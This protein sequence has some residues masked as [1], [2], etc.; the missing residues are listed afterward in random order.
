MGHLE[1]SELILNEDGSV[2][3]LGLKKE[4]IAAKVIVVGDQNRVEMISDFF[5]S[6]EFTIQKRE[7]KTCTGIYKGKRITVLSTGIGTD[8]ID[9]VL[10]ELDASIHIDPVSK[11]I[12]KNTQSL[13]IVRIGTCGS[14]Q[15]DIGVDEYIVSEHSIGIDGTLNF[16]ERKKDA[17]EE[18]LIADFMKYTE[19]HNDICTPYLTSANEALLHKIGFDMHKG[20]TITANG[21]YGPQ[22]R[23]LRLN[24]KLPNFNERLNSYR[25]KNQRIVNYEM[26]TSALYGLSNLLGHKALTVCLVVA[27][28]YKKQFS[29]D[30]KTSM[31]KLVEIVLDR[32]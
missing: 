28:R 3:H 22:G 29:K 21:F 24:T 23:V 2:Y 27:N 31:K 9:I 8:N 10:N 11:N 17:L 18:M 15:E 12:E 14:L 1:S 32:I 26:E 19:L 30:Y 4:H 16:Y 20:I 25:F 5:D 13:E 7:F 6:V